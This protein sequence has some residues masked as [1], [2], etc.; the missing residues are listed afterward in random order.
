MIFRQILSEADGCASY[1]LGCAVAG[2]GCVVDPLAAVGVDEYL[3]LA[4]ENELE[5]THV[6]DT[7]LHADHVSVARELAAAAGA[8]LHLHAAAPVA[9][10]F[11]AVRD[12][13][14]FDLGAVRLRVL[15]TP[16][17]TDESLSLL[18]WD[19]LRSASDPWLV[20]TGD[21][22]LAGDVAR[23]D[24]SLG[25]ADAGAVRR[26]AATLHATLAERLLA[27]PDWVEVWPGHFGASTCGGRNL[28]PKATTTIGFERR[29]NE[30]L[31]RPSAE[32][33]VRFVLATLRA[34]PADYR[35][36]KSG[37][38]AGRPLPP[39]ADVAPADGPGDLPLIDLRP[40]RA[41]LRAHIPGS[42]NRPFVRPWQPPTQP[43][44]AVAP[45]AAVARAAGATVWFRLRDWESAG[46]PVD[47]VAEADP[48]ALPAGAR[49]IDVREPSEWSDG[50]LPGA[51]CVAA[52]RLPAG[53]A[54]GQDSVLY[55]ATGVR[56]ADLAR[57]LR[58]LGFDGIRTLAGGVAGWRLAGGA[59]VPPP[60]DARP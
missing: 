6:F 15:H 1:L 48:A 5:L 43:F 32:E 27:L 29:N 45:N 10:P 8:R 2:A 51:C 20:L 19:R 22:L 44:A 28:S 9:Y 42:P 33:F 55:C 60:A 37:N 26:R 58:E 16:G 17:H 49:L 7:H 35:A 34:E 31:R 21:S 39:A 11:D 12:G 57:R 23:P 18:V 13:D 50:I 59:L 46:R 3:L 30:A 24:L 25:A 56:S 40:D 36:I 52:D 14:T 41:Y 47:R 38:A 4:A 54:A 53:L